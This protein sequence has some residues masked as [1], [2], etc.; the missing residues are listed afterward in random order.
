[1]NL[2]SLKKVSIKKRSL[3]CS[4]HHEKNVNNY[5][6]GIKKSGSLS[7]EQSKKIKPVRGRPVIFYR[8]CKVHKAITNVFHHLNLYFLQFGTPSYK[9]AKFLI[10]KL[11]NYV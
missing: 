9:L 8:L 2:L 5:L 7:T 3:N 10:P 6:K 1:M 11:F 4:I